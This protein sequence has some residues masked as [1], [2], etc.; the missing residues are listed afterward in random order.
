MTTV[1]LRSLLAFMLMLGVGL[2]PLAAK[3]AVP[4]GVMDMSTTSTEAMADGMPCCPDDA[5]AMPDC[6]K[7]CPLLATC[8]TTCAPATPVALVIER[9]SAVN[10][11][12]ASPGDD[13]ARPSPDAGPPSRPPRS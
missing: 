4:V 9:R 5:P 12:A 3:A 11:A 6:R 1:V 2:T 7:S 8:M 13:A 10:F